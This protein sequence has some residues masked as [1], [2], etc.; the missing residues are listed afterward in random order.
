MTHYTILRMG[1]SIVNNKYAEDIRCLQQEYN[2]CS[3]DIKKYGAT[4]SLHLLPS[5]LVL[6]AFYLNFKYR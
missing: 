6:K 4:I 1:M 2:S 5:D 3:K